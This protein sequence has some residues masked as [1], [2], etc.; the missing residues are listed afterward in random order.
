L[1]V[2]V[3]DGNIVENLHV[4][5]AHATLAKMEAISVLGGTL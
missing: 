5:T 3:V 1:G 2:A 4:E